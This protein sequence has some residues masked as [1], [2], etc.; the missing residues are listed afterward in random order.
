MAL[1]TIWNVLNLGVKG[2]TGNGKEGGAATRPSPLVEHPGQSQHSRELQHHAAHSPVYTMCWSA[3]WGWSF[4]R[5]S[6]SLWFLQAPISW[7]CIET[8]NFLQAPLRGS[9]FHLTDGGFYF[10]ASSIG[11]PSP[12]SR[13]LP[14][15]LWL[16]EKANWG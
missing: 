12:C 2:V 14:I 4:L 5:D 13:S 11:S 1:T 15:C 16:E 6:S 8:S 9:H 3:W 10:I 7:F